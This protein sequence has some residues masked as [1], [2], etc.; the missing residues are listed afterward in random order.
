M[1]IMTA[2]T[3]Y[4]FICLFLI[5]LYVSSNNQKQLLEQQKK[6][7]EQLIEY[8]GIIEE[9]YDNIRNQKHDFLNVLFSIKGYVDNGQI[10]EFKEYYRNSVLKEYAEKQPKQFVSSLNLIKHAGIKGILSYKLSHAVSLGIKVCLNIFTP[11]EFRVVDSLDLCRIIGILIDNAVEASCEST[12]KELHIGLESD[13]AMTSV[14]ISNTYLKEPDLS[15]MYKRGY[16]SRGKNR[17][18]G[19]Y[20]VEN[21]LSRYPSVELKSSLADNMFYHELIING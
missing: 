17:G 12:G 14:I 8:T 4:F 6:E 7:Y 18:V 10:E 20:N 19:L 3:I 16:S 11:I 9:L 13:S 1:F 2:S 21:I 5:Y 15:Q